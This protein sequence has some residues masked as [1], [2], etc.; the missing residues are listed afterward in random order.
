[1]PAKLVF[2]SA[3]W[4]PYRPLLSLIVSI[5]STL[6]A[7]LGMGRGAAC[8]AP[9]SCPRQHCMNFL[10]RG[11]AFR[12]SIHNFRSAVR[13]ITAHKYLRVLGDLQLLAGSLADRDDHHVACDGLRPVRGSH[14]QAG[15]GAIPQHALRRGVEPEGAAVALRKLVFIVI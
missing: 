5:S 8:C 6:F 10:R 11:D 13:A 12:S 2:K 7:A 9:T 14:F 1:M 15:H 4:L 3:M